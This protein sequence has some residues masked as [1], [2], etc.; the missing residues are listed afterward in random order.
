M[1]DQQDVLIMDMEA[2]VEHLGRGTAA[3][4]DWLLVVLEPSR[5]SAATAGRIRV[6]AEQ[7][8]I[9][10]VGA[11]GNKSR[12]EQETAFLAEAVA[13]LHLLGVL[14]YDDGLRLAEMT[15]RPPEPAG[16][17]VAAALDAVIARLSDREQAT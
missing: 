14:P 1:L 8:G 2:G 12:S 16:P 3:A 5:Q 9:P 13:P 7:I 17:G 4:V 10:R 15:G 11:V 6:L